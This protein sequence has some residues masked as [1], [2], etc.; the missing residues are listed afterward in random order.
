MTMLILTRTTNPKHTIKLMNIFFE[1]NR[2]K[3]VHLCRYK[4]SSIKVGDALLREKFDDFQ[5]TSLHVKYTQNNKPTT[6]TEHLMPIE[7]YY[8]AIVK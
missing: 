2:Q 8:N 5:M 7:T 4:K 6:S 1:N 3:S